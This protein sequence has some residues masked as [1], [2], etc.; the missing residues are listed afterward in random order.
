MSLPYELRPFDR[1]HDAGFV[2]GTYGACCAHAPGIRPEHRSW[3]K[4]AGQSLCLRVV[5]DPRWQT[6]VA[7]LGSGQLVGWVCGRRENVKTRLF[8]CYVKTAFRRERIATALLRRAAPSGD[9]V[10]CPM[11]VGPVG[12]AW[13]ERIGARPEESK[14]P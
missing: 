10:Y 8:G 6:W 7:V 5:D 14:I 2:L 13:L 9:I 3:V 4:R 11:P 12:A 1:G